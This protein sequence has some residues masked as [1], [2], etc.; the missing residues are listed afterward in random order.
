M[1]RVASLCCLLLG[2]LTAA[3]AAPGHIVTDGGHKHL[4]DPQAR[5]AVWG[6]RPA[7]TDTVVNW[8]RQ[9]G[10]TVVDPNTL[11]QR[12]DQASIKV[13]RSFT[14]EQQAVALAKELDV[15]LIIF[16]QSV[17]GVIVVGNTDTTTGNPYPGAVPTAFSHAA[18]TLKG[19]HVATTETIL[20]AT[21]KYPPQR[22]AA[23]PDTLALLACRALTTAWGLAPPGE[24]AISRQDP[25]ATA[26]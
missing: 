9:R 13:S 11:Q 10:F 21:A 1:R 25:C 26:R 16:T 12:F 24:Q 14:D 5:I 22:A 19:V 2:L 20:S 7:V 8:L 4:P 6:L 17:L 23:G 15:G 3:C 18:V